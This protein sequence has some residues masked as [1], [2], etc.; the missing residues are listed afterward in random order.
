VEP[1]AATR[2]KVYHGLV[3]ECAE[4]AATLRS[5]RARAV[6]T[7]GRSPSQDGCFYRCA[8]WRTA[9]SAPHSSVSHDQRLWSR[10]RR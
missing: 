3:R 8:K 1:K 9:L 7:V 4:L 5:R 10:R 2:G 6:F